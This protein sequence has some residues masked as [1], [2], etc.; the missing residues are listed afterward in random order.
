[1]IRFDPATGEA[2]VLDDRLPWN[3]LDPSAVWDD[4]ARPDHGCPEGCAYVF[5]GDD[6]ARYDPSTGDIVEMNVT[7]PAPADGSAA[8]WAGDRAY[9]FG[10]HGCEDYCDHVIAFDPDEPSARILS[11]RMSKGLSDPSAVWTGEAA[12]VLGGSNDGGRNE[13]RRFDPANAT[14]SLLDT[15]L[16]FRTYDAGAVYDGHNVFLL[17]GCCQQTVERRVQKF[18]P[19][20]ETA[21]LLPDAVFP[22]GRDRLGAVWTGSAAYALGGIDSE[23]KGKRDV[24]RLTLEPGQPRD[25]TAQTDPGL[26]SP[27]AVDRVN[28]TWKP[29]AQ[30]TYSFLTSHEVYR[31]PAAGPGAG[32]AWTHVAS[33]PA[34]RTWF[35]DDVDRPGAFEYAVSG[36]N[37]HRREGPLAIQGNEAALGAGTFG[38]LDGG[39]HG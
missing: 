37:D 38:L 32:G 2:D 10:G 22:Q 30:E 9:V 31:R 39:Q 28:V 14:I 16:P 29:P 25:V 20:N 3:A 17:G 33:V 26:P 34:D 27:W 4:R 18:D 7:L 24:F 5:R 11:D 1:V 15:Q 6:V 8:V 23:G 35:L 21:S 13:I 19:G 36:V 12:Y